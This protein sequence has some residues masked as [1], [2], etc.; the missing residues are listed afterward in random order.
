MSDQQTSD[1]STNSTVFTN[2]T[3]GSTQR[4]SPWHISWPVLIALLI[5][6][7]PVGLFALAKRGTAKMWLRILVGLVT[8]PVFAILVLILLRSYWQFGGDMSLKSF[9]LDFSRGS[10]HD[11]EVEQHRAEQSAL[12]APTLTPDPALL[13]LSWPAFRGRERD[14]IVRDFTDISTNWEKHPPRELWRQP[15]GDGYASFVI[16]NGRLFTIEQRRSREAIVSYDIVTGREFW[17]Y[18]YG[19]FFVEHLGGNGPRATPT[20]EGDR[21]YALGAEGEFTCLDSA[22]GK[23]IWSHNI[24]TEFGAQNLQWGMSASLLIVDDKVIITN[25]GIGGGSIMAYRCDDGKLVWQTDV[26]QQGYSSPTIATLLGRRQ[27]LNFAAF[28]LNGIDPET[29]RRLWSFP[30]KTSLGISCSQPLAIDDSRI[31]IS[32]GYGIG[33]AMVRLEKQ[34]DSIAAKEFWSTV[35]MKNKFTSSVI[36]NGALYGLDEDILACIDIETGERKWKGGRYGYGSVLLIGNYL[37]VSGEQGELALVE[38]MPDAFR[39]IGRI[40]IFDGKTWNNAAVA[41]GLLFARN[42]KEMVCYDLRTE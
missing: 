14:G 17:K 36:Y 3:K 4:K 9:Y 27:I 10:A 29:G 16:G 39:E 15:V 8:L 24:L 25:S 21:L 28:E 30:W 19:S 22:T 38:A 11:L 40:S 1:A 2:A 18:E 12:S 32:L 31:F 42:H 5:L 26:G 23:R 33:S 6:A 34:G 37:L 20:L 41:G 35:K 7:Y 13:R